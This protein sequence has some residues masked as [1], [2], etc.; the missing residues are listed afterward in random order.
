MRLHSDIESTLDKSPELLELASW[1]RSVKKA[2]NLIIGHLTINE[3]PSILPEKLKKIIVGHGGTSYISENSFQNKQEVLFDALDNVLLSNSKNSR[4]TNEIDEKNKS[5]LYN[6]TDE[7]YTEIDSKLNSWFHFIINP[8]PIEQSKIAPG[9]ICIYEDA[10]LVKNYSLIDDEKLSDFL[11]YQIEKKSE[12]DSA[13]NFK[14]IVLLLTR[15]CDIAQNKYGKNLKLL[16]GLKIINPVRKGGESQKRF[17]LKRNSS[18]P[19]SLKIL[20]HLFF[21]EKEDDVVLMFDFRYAFSVSKESFIKD[22][23]KIKIISKELL[24]EIQVEYSSYS[25]RL[26]TTQ[27]I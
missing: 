25:S 20:D 15:P 12:D 4:P 19:D 13:L 26:G 23:K 16:S 18:Q 1:K 5:I 7:I 27:I 21:S 8:T 17:D 14:N 3:K 9:L 2:S 6:I 22:F 24:S 11:K 10:E